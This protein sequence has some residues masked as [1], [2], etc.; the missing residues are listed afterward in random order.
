[1][2]SFHSDILFSIN[3]FLNPIDRSLLK[4][5]CKRFFDY[6]KNTPKIENIDDLFIYSSLQWIQRK[7]IKPN[8]DQVQLLAQYGHLEVL[9]IYQR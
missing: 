4:C 1:M 8:I 3:L 6:W 9:R 2:Q 5:T 7:Q